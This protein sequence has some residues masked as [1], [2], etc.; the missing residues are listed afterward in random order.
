MCCRTWGLL[1][2]RSLK[3]STLTLTVSQAFFSISAVA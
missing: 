1:H 3:S 2:K